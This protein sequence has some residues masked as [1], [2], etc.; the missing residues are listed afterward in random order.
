MSVAEAEDEFSSIVEKVYIP[1]FD[2]PFQRTQRLRKT[3]EEMLTKMGLE[4]D[5][6]LETEWERNHCAGY[7]LT[8]MQFAPEFMKGYQICSR[9]V[10]CRFTAKDMPPI[11]QDPKR[12]PLRYQRRRCHASNMCFK[13]NICASE[14][15]S[16]L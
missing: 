15:W 9:S 12:A 5:A 14:C 16:R 1:Q 6:K 7:E 4:V 11:L 10:S 8:C 3:I 13:H 2:N